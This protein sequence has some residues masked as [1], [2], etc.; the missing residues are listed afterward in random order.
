MKTTINHEQ[1]NKDGYIKI[2]GF[3][4]NS[5]IKKLC[6]YA[7]EILTWKPSNDKWL[8][9]YEKTGPNKLSVSRVE[10]F[11]DYH[12]ELKGVLFSDDRIETFLQELLYDKVA[13]LKERFI[14]R[15]PN[16]GGYL[17]HQD[18]Y[19]VAYNLPHFE[20]HAIVAIFLDK[21]TEGNG[22][23]NFCCDPH[24]RRTALPMD[25]DGRI[26]PNIY[27]E[28]QW[29]AEECNPGD[30]VIF[31]NYTPHYSNPNYS[32]YS[33]RA[34]YLTYMKESEKLLT[35]KEYFEKKREIMPPEVGIVN[36]NKLK[37]Q[38]HV[39]THHINISN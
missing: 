30:V 21:A 17:P 24:H 26:L 14:F 3:F 22:C 23:L 33:R 35:R 13:L 36:M 1:W 31:D 37:K 28:F 16:S 29:K 11:L 9:W 12:N 15:A 32:N 27:K 34:I 10:N 2:E 38:N 5:E 20:V 39:V 25:D 6:K 19:S 7:D 4:K 8:L 18:I